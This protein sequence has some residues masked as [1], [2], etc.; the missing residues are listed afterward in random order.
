MGVL[1]DFRSHNERWR[2]LA[3]F[4]LAGLEIDIEAKGR[5][6]APRKPVCL[7][8]WVQVFKL[9]VGDGSPGEPLQE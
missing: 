9:G 4:S 7:L 3:R 2:P 8:G 6:K 1:Y 5:R